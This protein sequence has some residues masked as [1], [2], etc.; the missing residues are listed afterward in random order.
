MWNVRRL[1]SR[2]AIASQGEILLLGRRESFGEYLW[3][4]SAVLSTRAVIIVF[5]SE[6][7]DQ[8]IGLTGGRRR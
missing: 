8:K 4:L 2:S 3:E 6:S 5:R 7:L 1:L